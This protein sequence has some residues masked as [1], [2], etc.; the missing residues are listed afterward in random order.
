[1]EKRAQQKK[2]EKEEKEKQQQKQPAIRCKQYCVHLRS[3]CPVGRREGSKPDSKNLPFR[4]PEVAGEAL[5]SSNS[6]VGGV[7]DCVGCV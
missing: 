4:R 1:M 3:K 2:E 7:C 5:R 6:N